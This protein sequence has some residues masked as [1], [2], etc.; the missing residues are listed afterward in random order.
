M[1]GV[2]SYEIDVESGVPQGSVLGP[3]LF[4][5][6]INDLS[7]NINN[8]QILTFADDTKLIHPII[9]VHDS[10]SLQNDL[11]SVIEWS[12]NNNMLLNKNKFE[13][14]CYKHNNANRKR[15]EELPFNSTF[16]PEY[17]T[18]ENTYISKSN[19]VRDLGIL[20]NPNLDWDDH[21]LNLSKVGKRLTSWILSVFY[22]RSKDVMLTL[23]N[24]LVRSRL[25]YCCQIWNPYK[26]KHIDAIENVQRIFTRKIQY[27]DSYNYWER[28]KILK[29][30]SLQ[31]RREKMIIIFV[32]MI[33]NNKVTN[34][35]N[36]QFHTDRKG[37]N[38]VFI[39][40]FPKKIK[41]ELLSIYENSF[42]IKSGK[43]WNKLPST[44]SEI[45]NLTLFKKKLHE[46]LLL[47][48]DEP[49]VNGYYHPNYNSLLEYSSV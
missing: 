39:R 34:S 24:S 31:R 26:L 6:Y 36:L 45:D 22:D 9:T 3:L 4:I 48:P 16:F 27:M 1:N 44:I 30:M 11:N 29:I 7:L 40:P 47:Y 28:L 25:E 23:F 35:I 21:I 46:Y 12:N 42:I 43:L 41:G 17:E 10:F 38:K 49:P 2:R 18:S 20:I 32:W 19:C 14:I 15:F 13:L 8:S 37:N 33:K 5:L